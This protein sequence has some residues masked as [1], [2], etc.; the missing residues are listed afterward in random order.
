MSAK[1][2]AIQDI[3][4]ELELNGKCFLAFR[5]ELNPVM[6][7]LVSNQI[8][9]QRRKKSYHSNAQ[10][11]ARC[12]FSASNPK[13]ENYIGYYKQWKIILFSVLFAAAAL[14]IGAAIGNYIVG[15]LKDF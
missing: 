13:Y 2:L 7:R 5:T 10:I 15:K 14:I 6:K 11:M 1:D 9:A 4:K 3:Q 12:F 8:K